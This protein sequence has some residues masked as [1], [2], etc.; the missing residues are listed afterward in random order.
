MNATPDLDLF[1]QRRHRA[2]NTLHTWLLGAGS[3][4]LLAVTA[5]VFAGLCRFRPAPVSSAM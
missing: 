4:L 1:E 3:L 2:M 5:F